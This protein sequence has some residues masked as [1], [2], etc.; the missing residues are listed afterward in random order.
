MLQRRRRGGSRL[1]LLPPTA[2]GSLCPA[3]IWRQLEAHKHFLAH[4]VLCCSPVT[5]EPLDTA[6]PPPPPIPAAGQRKHLCPGARVLAPQGVTL[7]LEGTAGAALEGL[8]W[9]KFLGGTA[10]S[11][12]QRC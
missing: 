12:Q 2:S 3:A 6:A 1:A 5:K 11:G 8:C 9:Q 10:L 4:R 7:G